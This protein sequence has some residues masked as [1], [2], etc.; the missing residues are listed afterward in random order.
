[1]NTQT[2]VQNPTVQRRSFTGRFHQNF[3]NH[4]HYVLSHNENTQCIQTTHCQCAGTSSRF[5][6]WT[7]HFSV[8]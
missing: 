5:S 8:A 1:M 4:Y 3:A 2:K 7:G 6:D